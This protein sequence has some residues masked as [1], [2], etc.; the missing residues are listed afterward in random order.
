MGKNLKALLFFLLT[1]G[2]LFTVFTLWTYRAGLLSTEI[3]FFSFRAQQNPNGVAKNLFLTYPAL[4]SFFAFLYPSVILLP[5]TTGILVTIFLLPRLFP[6]EPLLLG[7]SILATIASPF[8]LSAL[9]ITPTLLLFFVLL[10]CALSNL[11]RYQEEQSVYH[12]FLGGI[13]FGA[14]ILTHPQMEWFA[15]ATAIFVLFFFPGNLTRKFGLLLVVFFPVL[16]FLGIIMFLNWGYTTQ[17]LSL[18]RFPEKGWRQEVLSFDPE[19][20]LPKAAKKGTIVATEKTR[21]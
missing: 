18:L 6:T 3:H 2:I 11:L 5:V 19:T 10:L 7:L 17:A 8:F 21:N 1:C 9:S 4:P 14:T 13:F 16:A 15:L 12:L 20:C